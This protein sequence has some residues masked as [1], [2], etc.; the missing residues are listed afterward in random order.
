MFKKFLLIITFVSSLIINQMVF[1]E[2]SVCR[3]SLNEMVQSI[4]LDAAQK[5]KIKPILDQLK[6]T[7]KA[8]ES[9]MEALKSQITQQVNSANMDQGKVNS[10]VDEKTKLIG[11]VMKAKIMAKNQIFALLNPQQK[12]KLQ[13]MIKKS[14][15]KMTAL[16]KKCYRD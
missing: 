8:N 3:E 10:L 7:F 9:Q 11:E 5:A 12:G 2:S 15:E 1:A 14:D 6:S 4:N 16:F 13:E